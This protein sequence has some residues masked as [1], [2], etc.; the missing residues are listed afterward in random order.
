M[1]V[2]TEDAVLICKHVLG[3]VHN[4][5]SQSLVTVAGRRVLVENDPEGRT[6][7]GCPNIGAT[8]K[9]CTA[10]LKVQAGYSDWIRVDGHRICLDT[11]TGL[12]DGTPPGTVKYVV[13]EPGQ[14]FVSEA[15]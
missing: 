12:T 1:K 11:I 8:I 5:P 2:L 10:T 4:R 6:I 14:A 7:T 15:A 3:T 13:R 9:P